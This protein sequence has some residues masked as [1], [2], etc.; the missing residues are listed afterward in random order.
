MTDIDAVIDDALGS[1]YINPDTKEFHDSEGKPLG[2]FFDAN[3]RVFTSSKGV[4]MHFRK[5]NSMMLFKLSK[6]YE[7]R[8]KPQVPKKEVQYAKNK[9][10]WIDNPRDE[11]YQRELLNYHQNLNYDIS[12]KMISLS[13]TNDL[14][15]FEDMDE[16]TQISLMALEMTEW[17]NNPQLKMEVK[18]LWAMNQVNTDLELRVLIAVTQGAEVPTLEALEASA[19][20][21]P[22]S[23]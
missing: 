1:F 6:Q 17:E 23:D 5:L 2:F 7:D 8:H 15:A 10:T 9:T 21:F 18:A 14:P 19:E 16:D 13:L 11:Y 20:R 22:S 4:K 3:E 12:E